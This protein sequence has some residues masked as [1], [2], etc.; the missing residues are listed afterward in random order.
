MY[1]S[2][3]PRAAS[4]ARRSSSPIAC[5]SSGAAVASPGDDGE[6]VELLVGTGPNQVEVR[7]DALQDRH[8]DAA[9]LLQQGE[10]QMN[11]RDLWVTPAVCQA[12]CGLERLLRL[13][14]EAVRLHKI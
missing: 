5:P 2:P 6:A 14:G 1:S 9:L 7:P 4:S 8:D 13:Y 12:L 10:Q 11:R 3:I